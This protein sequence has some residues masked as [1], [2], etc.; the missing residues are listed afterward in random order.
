MAYRKT[1]FVY[2]TSEF[3][4]ED[5][6][7]LL[8]EEKERKWKSLSPEKRKAIWVKLK[9]DFPYD[10]GGEPLDPHKNWIEAWDTEENEEVEEAWN[11]HPYVTQEIEEKVSEIEKDIQ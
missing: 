11:H 2:I 9:Q 10:V 6:I 1:I 5:F 4:E 7:S 3:S 8:S